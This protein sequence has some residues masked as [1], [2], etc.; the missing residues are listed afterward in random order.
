[1]VVAPE[2][3]YSLIEETKKDTILVTVTIQYR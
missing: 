1:V 2:S 3:H